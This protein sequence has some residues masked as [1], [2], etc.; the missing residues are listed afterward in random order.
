MVGGDEHDPGFGS[1]TGAWVTAF[2]RA[3]RT[4]YDTAASA[5][6]GGPERVYRHLGEALLQASPSP[7]KGA[8]LVD[9]GAGTGVVG[10]V[11]TGLGARCIEVDVA[12]EM[13]LHQRP[14]PRRTVAADGRRLPF[15]S[16]TYD[17]ATAACSLS[18]LDDPAA[19]LREV[20]RVLRPGGMLLAS[21][22]PASSDP[23]PVRASVDEALA[24]SGYR[25]PLWYEHLK[26]AGE[27]R[28]ETPNALHGLGRSAAF[29]A[30][31]VQQIVVDTGISTPEALV[32]YRLGMAQHTQFLATL[33]EA[34]RQ[35]IRSRAITLLGQSPPPLTMGLLVL[36]ART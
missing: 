8:L 31:D 22:F 32:D 2:D 14:R 18:H 11:A 20:R 27:R 33:D 7:L 4:A 12:V 25:R 15:R 26:D 9:I 28:I 23:H 19:M 34:A 21:A 24:E 36:S 30:V 35:Q 5:W 10:D 29:D 13:L 6:A 17:V 16:A 3:T 1:H